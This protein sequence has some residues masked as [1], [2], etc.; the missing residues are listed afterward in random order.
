[1]GWELRM[2]LSGDYT[3]LNIQ[4]QSCLNS[5][6]LSLTLSHSRIYIKYLNAQFK[7][8]FLKSIL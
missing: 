4:T 6:P 8:G 5:G 3:Y 7:K 1:M 2:E